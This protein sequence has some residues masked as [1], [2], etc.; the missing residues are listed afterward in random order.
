MF[1]LHPAL[2]ERPRD[3]TGRNQA[4]RGGNLSAKSERGRYITL[5]DVYAGEGLKTRERVYTHFYL[6]KPLSQITALE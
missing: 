3:G 5:D 2:K 1:I 6:P 4:G